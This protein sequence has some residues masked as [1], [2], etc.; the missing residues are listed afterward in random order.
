MAALVSGTGKATKITT[1][2]ASANQI[3]VAPHE[4]QAGVATLS[5]MGHQTNITPATA[6]DL[7]PVLQRFAQTGSL[8]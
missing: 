6:A 1:V 3:V 8:V 4:T 2:D 5:V 7:W